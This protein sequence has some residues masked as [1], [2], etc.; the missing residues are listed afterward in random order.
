MRPCPLAPSRAPGPRWLPERAP[1]RQRATPPSEGRGRRSTAPT[2]GPGVHSPLQSAAWKVWGSPWYPP[3]APSGDLNEQREGAPDPSG[4]GLG[5]L[6]RAGEDRRGPSAR[7]GA[8][9]LN[10]SHVTIPPGAQTGAAVSRQLPLF[11]PTTSK[12]TT[13]TPCSILHSVSP[14]RPTTAPAAAFHAPFSPA[15]ASPCRRRQRGRGLGRGA[16]SATVP[17]CPA[18]ANESKASDSPPPR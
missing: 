17:A 5:W 1:R 18:P 8:A 10:S 7:Q 14:S 16:Q 15:R 6:G 11:P 9:L 3:T 13:S 4:R 2:G 12:T